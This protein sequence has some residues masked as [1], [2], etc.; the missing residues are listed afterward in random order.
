[1]SSGCSITRVAW[2]RRGVVPKRLGRMRPKF[3]VLLAAA[4]LAIPLLIVSA[5]PASAHDSSPCGPVTAWYG[6][7]IQYCPLWTAPV[8]VYAGRDQ[9]TKRVGWLYSASGNW[10]ICQQN[11][12]SAT[13]HY[14]PYYNNWWAYTVADNLYW[15]WVPEVYFQGGGNNEPDATLRKG[16]C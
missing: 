10:F 6:Y 5:S 12:G 3:A 11:H 1:L 13:A 4:M 2:K 7:E 9:S 14:G 8:P 15:G 16:L